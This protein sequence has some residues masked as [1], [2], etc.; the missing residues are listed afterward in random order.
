MFVLRAVADRASVPL[1]ATPPTLV[2]RSRRRTWIRIGEPTNPNSSR[3]LLIRNRSYEK[4]NVVAT[5]VKKTN[6]GGATPV[7]AA[8]MIRTCLRPGL[9]GGFAAVTFSMNLLSAG[10]GTRMPPRRGDLV[11][12]LEHL[13]RALAG[14]RRDVEDRRVVEEAHA[15]AQRRRRT[16]ATNVWSSV[17]T[18]SHLLAMITMPRPARSASPPIAAS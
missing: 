16:A 5:L 12:R 6:D 7:C 17:F 1:R 3:S 11:H 18:R 2:F 10:V 14:Q 13:R 15:V 8:Y 9:T 4:W